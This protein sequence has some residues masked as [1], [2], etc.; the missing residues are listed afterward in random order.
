MKYFNFHELTSSATA[1]RLGIANQP[2][3]EEYAALTALVD[4]VLDPARK[5]YGMPIIVTSGYRS[6][7]LNKAVG[8]VANSQHCKGEA[9]DITAGRPDFNAYLA[10]IIYELGVFD[11]LILEEASG[12]G[13]ECQWVHVSYC[14]TGNRRQVMIKVKGHKGY[15]PFGFK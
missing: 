3:A 5:R 2:T 12:D 15:R 11:Q 4:N 13:T 8:G 6:A 7:A 1:L 10:R 14:R 9:A